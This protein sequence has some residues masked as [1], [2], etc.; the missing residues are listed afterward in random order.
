MEKYLRETA[1][2]YKAFCDENRLYILELLTEGEHCA[3]ELLEKLQISQ[4]TLSHHMK[5]L[6]DAQVVQGRRDGKWMYY[7]IDK[8][9]IK[10]AQKLLETFT[11]VKNRKADCR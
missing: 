1:K 2:I 4:S 3:C 6:T 8:E 5:I 11:E 9:G 10:K 7:T